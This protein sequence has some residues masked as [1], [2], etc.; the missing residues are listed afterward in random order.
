MGTPILIKD[1]MPQE[2]WR[3]LSEMLDIG[4]V[5]RR[6]PTSSFSSRHVLEIKAEGLHSHLLI[7]LT[8]VAANLIYPISVHIGGV[9]GWKILDL[10]F[11]KSEKVLG[12]PVATQDSFYMLWPNFD[13]PLKEGMSPVAN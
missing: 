4:F 12:S 2:Y 8:F 10:K 7:F 11:R 13:L 1:D 6:T 9:H 3:L 5:G